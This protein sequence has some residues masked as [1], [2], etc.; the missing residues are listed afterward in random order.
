MRPLISWRAR[1]VPLQ[2]LTLCHG[3]AAAPSFA[4]AGIDSPPLPSGNQEVA[5]PLECCLA[6]RLDRRPQKYV[7]PGPGPYLAPHQAPR[8]VVL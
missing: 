2:P 6:C 4:T 1:A 5:Q 7:D 3:Q 8:H